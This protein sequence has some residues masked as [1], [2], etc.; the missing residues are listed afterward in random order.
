MHFRCLKRQM[1]LS[2]EE[3]VCT[4]MPSETDAP[5]L[6]VLKPLKILSLL[7]GLRARNHMFQLK[8]PAVS[9]NRSSEVEAKTEFK[10]ILI[11]AVSLCLRA[12]PGGILPNHEALGTFIR[13][14]PEFFTTKVM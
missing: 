9:I 1:H 3:G 13:A 6:R 5:R 8:I 7:L 4:S 11:K 14:N 12:F 10:V 2:E